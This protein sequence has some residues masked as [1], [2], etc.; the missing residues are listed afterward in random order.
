MPKSWFQWSVQEPLG[1]AWFGR[2]GNAL[3]DGGNPFTPVVRSIESSGRVTN[4]QIGTLAT[5]YSILKAD[6]LE[7]AVELAKGCSLLQSGGQIS[8]YETAPVTER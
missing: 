4:S 7:A 6:S 3:A 1:S 2:L 8:V 5:G